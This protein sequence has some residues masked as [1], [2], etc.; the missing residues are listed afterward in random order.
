[1][2]DLRFEPKTIDEGT[3]YVL[4][5]QGKAK[6]LYFKLNKFYPFLI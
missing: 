3:C 6:Y 5:S 2:L 1:M 4:E